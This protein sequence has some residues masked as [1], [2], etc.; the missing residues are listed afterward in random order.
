MNRLFLLALGVAGGFG[1]AVAASHFAY[2]AIGPHA[3][4]QSALV[5]FAEAFVAVRDNYL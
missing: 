1:L 2:G 3:A 4:A 5:R